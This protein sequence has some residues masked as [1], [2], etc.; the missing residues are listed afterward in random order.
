[1]Q[2]RNLIGKKSF[3]ISKIETSNAVKNLK[4]ICLLSEA[5]LIDRG[6]LSRYFKIE[7]IP[8]IKKKIIK[9]AKK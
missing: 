2:I 3:L 9:I 8:P 5:V 1:M 7:K 4:S 6:D